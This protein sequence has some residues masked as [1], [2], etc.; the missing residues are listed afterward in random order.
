[1]LLTVFSIDL[2]MAVSFIKYQK[3]VSRYFKVT[4]ATL[5]L[6]GDLFAGLYYYEQST[7]IAIIAFAVLMINSVYLVMCYRDKKGMI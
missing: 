1:M 5:K 7:I 6:M 3:T 2:I 4:I